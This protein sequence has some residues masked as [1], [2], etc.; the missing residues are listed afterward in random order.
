MAAVH[1][2]SDFH[3][4]VTSRGCFQTPKCGILNTSDWNERMCVVIC[5]ISC[6]LRRA[7]FYEMAISV[8]ASTACQILI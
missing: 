3:Q 6:I 8:V 5:T 4:Q 2:A 1:E 7:L